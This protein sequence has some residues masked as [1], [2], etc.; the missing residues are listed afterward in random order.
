MA[1]VDYLAEHADQV[2]M[3]DVLCYVR[4]AETPD[5]PPDLKGELIPRLQPLVDR[6]VVKDPDQWEKYVLTPLEVVESPESPFADPLADVLPANL[7]FEIAHQA[8]SGAWEPKWTWGGLHPEAWAQ[9]KREWSGVITVRT[10]TTL[11]RF[12][13]L[14]GE[15]RDA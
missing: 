4:L 7:D 2:G 6:L 1:V 3:F 8:E 10:L 15:A 9:A 5:L 13:R 12:G 11:K 14:E